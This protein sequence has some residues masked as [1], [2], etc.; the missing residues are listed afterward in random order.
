MINNEFLSYFRPRCAEEIEDCEIDF[1]RRH[2]KKSKQLYY[3]AWCGI[4]KLVGIPKVYGEI[5]VV[6]GLQ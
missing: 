5:S 1:K 2:H 4:L 3:V 6:S